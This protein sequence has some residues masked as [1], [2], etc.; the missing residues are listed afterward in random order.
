MTEVP[1]HVPFHSTS[2]RTPAASP[3]FDEML[4]ATSYSKASSKP[5]DPS[6]QV[7]RHGDTRSIIR[8]NVV[9]KYFPSQQWG[10]D[11][12]QLQKELARSVPNAAELSSDTQATT[13]GPVRKG[14][15]GSASEADA[16]ADR[17]GS[18]SVNPALLRAE[19]AEPI[20]VTRA[21]SSSVPHLGPTFAAEIKVLNSKEQHL[22]R[23]ALGMY[24]CGLQYI[25]IQ[26]IALMLFTD[27]P[28]LIIYV[29][30]NIFYYSIKI[31][32]IFNCTRN[33]FPDLSTFKI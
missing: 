2:S 24:W 4:S 20:T 22:V 26:R 28:H 5:V 12:Y 1:E 18:I 16:E 10:P 15:G 11:H 27:N 3:P 9:F 32:N 14:S 25:H 29:Y 19:L 13:A 33:N 31:V 21:T 7:A 30:V 23:L 6:R 8:D 17:R